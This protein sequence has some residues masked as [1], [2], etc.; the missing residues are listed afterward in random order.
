[1]HANKLWTKNT[2]TNTVEGGECLPRGFFDSSAAAAPQ[3]TKA[4]AAAAAAGDSKNLDMDKEFAD[5]MKEVKVENASPAVAATAAV[6]EEDDDEGAKLAR[7]D[8]EQ[9]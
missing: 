1:M 9:L 8:F 6:E 2:N 5:F 3:G 4:S 7:E